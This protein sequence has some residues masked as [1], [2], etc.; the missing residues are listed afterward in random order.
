MRRIASVMALLFSAFPAS[1]DWTGTGEVTKV[2]SHEGYHF[3]QTTIAD[4]PCGTAGKF[5]WPASDPDAKD[6]FAMSLAAV[7]AGK[8]VSVNYSGSTCSNGGQL[9]THM[10]IA[11]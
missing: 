6:M 10:M 1:A 4:N 8:F 5:W 7:A 2:W 11:K 3:I 9:V